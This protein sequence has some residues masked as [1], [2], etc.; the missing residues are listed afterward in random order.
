MQAAALHGIGDIR[1][2]QRERP[3]C[4]PGGMLL[5][6]ESC[7][8]CASDVKMWLR[9]HKEMVLPRV[10]GHE[11]VGRVEEVGSAEDGFDPGQRVQASPGVACGACPA[12]AQ[13]LQ[14]RCAQVKVLGFSMDGGM[15]DYV[16]LPAQSLAS[17]AINQVPENLDPATAT[18]AEPLACGLNALHNARLQ[19]GE[20][21]VIFGAGV[22]GR[23]LALA[24]RHLGAAQVLVVD[25]D[26]KRLA[27]TQGV[28]LDASKGFDRAEALRLLGGEASVVVPACPDP[29]ALLWGAELL[30]PGGRLVLFSGLGGS[31]DLDLNL[32]HYKELHLIGAYGCTNAQNREALGILSGHADWAQ[33]LIT[34]RMGIASAWEALAAAQSH[35]QLKVVIEP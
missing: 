24:G 1:I 10:L 30:E 25:I 11:L 31:A 34:Q 20:R 4:P 9:G 17:G 3:A 29:K 15:A 13:G 12:C 22:V 19:P 7:G 32:V 16:A 6:V 5:K 8:V 21:M 35:D 18:L 28:I 26:P 14:N 2:E 23:L 33:E 27:G